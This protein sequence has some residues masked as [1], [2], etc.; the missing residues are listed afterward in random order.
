MNSGFSFEIGIRRQS[1]VFFS[2]S[3]TPTGAEFRRAGKPLA[4]LTV[5][6]FLHFS[7]ALSYGVDI[8]TL[9]E[10]IQTALKNH[11][12]LKAADYSVEAAEES[13]REARGGFL[14]RVDLSE[15]LTRTTGP[16]EVFWTELSQ[17]RFSLS[18]FAITN[19][20]DPDGITN[21]NT[22]ITLVQPVYTGGKLRT[23]YQI[24]K[25]K[26]EAARNDRE[27]TRQEVIREFT[28]AYFGALLAGR[29]VEV[30]EKA[31]TAVQAHAKMARDLLDQGMVLRSDLLRARVHLSEVEARLITARNQRKLAAANLN[32][33]MGVDQGTE[34][35]LVY[36][37]TTG[38]MIDVGELHQLIEEAKENRPD[39]AELSLMEKTSE[40]GV[41]LARA[42]CLPRVN[43]VAR[44][45]RNDRDFLG[46]DGEYWTLMAVANI[47]LFEGFS[48][49]ARIHRAKAEKARMSSLVA[50]ATEGIELEV[51][52]AYLN[53]QEAEARLEI[54]R[55]SVSE[56]EE[57]I[58]IVEDRYRGGMGRITELLD[59]ETALTLA[60]THEARAL[61]DLNI[62]RTDLDLATGRL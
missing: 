58:R 57:S 14:P 52:S 23:G 16:G 50:Q 8:L 53:L 61:Y 19:P 3:T 9:Q 21:Y 5:L 27:R 30:A 39:L 7:A 17:E 24:S 49:R 25:L 6:L 48:S 36:E 22:Q 1:M 15:S 47:N 29:F 41:E 44:Y 28:A 54:A 11:P 18:D 37:E 42:S 12:G 43:L 55:R 31:R 34:Y 20:N 56:A 35:E 60:R 62:A 4:G 32:R 38:G 46:N 33:I 45:N 13:V 40:K 26:R 2:K 59:T 10:G 51:R